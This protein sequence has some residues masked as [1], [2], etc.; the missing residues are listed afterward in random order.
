MTNPNWL[1]KKK[2][3]L[4][5][6]TKNHEAELQAKLDSRLKQ[7][8]E[9]EG[10]LSVLCLALANFSRSSGGAALALTA[11]HAKSSREEHICSQKLQN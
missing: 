9:R 11:F 10:S 8:N 3:E 6:I 5:P 1:K 2:N 7:H 4:A